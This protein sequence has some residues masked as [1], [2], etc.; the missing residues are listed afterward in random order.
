MYRNFSETGGAEGYS[1]LIERS[2]P[3][4]ERLRKL[5][6]DI[7]T[8]LNKEAYDLHGLNGLLDAECQVKPQGYAKLYG[9]ELI[10]ESQAEVH[11]R[12]LEFSDALHPGTQKFYLETHGIEGEEQIIAKW[13]QEKRENKNT[14]MELAVTALLHKVLKERYFVVRTSEYDDYMNGIDNIIV[15]KET[16]VVICAFDEVHEGGDGSRTNDKQSKISKTARKD[17]AEIRFGLKVEDNKL[18][19]AGLENLPVF[20]LGLTTTELEDLMNHMNYEN[21]DQLSDK[22]KSTYLKLI[23]SVGEQMEL[24]QEDKLPE[25]VKQNLNRFQESFEALNSYP[26]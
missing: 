13:K 15:D 9:Q 20:Y 16:G 25:G 1:N 18:Q 21:M 22:E 11:E 3:P 10:D 26:K 24:L 4:R 5:I 6:K 12:E 14:Q 8:A 7:S 17:G 23:G 19:R 2:S